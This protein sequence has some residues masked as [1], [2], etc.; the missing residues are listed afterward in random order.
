ML[1]ACTATEQPSRASAIIRRTAACAGAGIVAAGAA[2]VFAA[3]PA[4]ADEIDLDE[5]SSS[6][7]E[8]HIAE[9][10]SERGD[11]ADRLAALERRLASSQA[12]VE[13][14]TADYG[15]ADAQLD[16][17]LLVVDAAED[18][19]GS[20]MSS[21]VGFA[22]EQSQTYD[23]AQEAAE[24]AAALET[25]IAEA[26]TAVA[27]LDEAI[28]QAETAAE[29]A[30]EEEAEAEAEALG[31]D[32][33]GSSDSTG[34]SGGGSTPSYSS[35]AATAAVEFAHDQLGES[36]VYGAAGPDTWDCSGL[37]QGAYAV[38]G[39]SLTHSTY[40]IWDETSALDRGDLRP[41][42][43]VFYNGLG[44]MAIYIGGGEV[45]HAPS[46]GDVVKVSDIDMMGIDG[47]RRV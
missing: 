24:E 32:S 44:H 45:I 14:A 9:L 43:L 25:E 3:S 6:E 23:E 16:Q 39:I 33:G 1:P 42:D 11:T 2:T 36:Y 22:R 27:E 5:A 40:A 28:E 7:I 37:V 31:T 21:L 26:E 17:V 34:G 19:L 35:D 20:K 38:S 18:D 4:E 30:A 15:T 12:I 41:G 47:Y 46:S 29:E 10:E 8:D 13:A